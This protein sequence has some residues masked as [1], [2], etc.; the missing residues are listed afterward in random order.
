MADEQNQTTQEAQTAA[1]AP[2][3]GSSTAEQENPALSAAQPAE[4]TFTQSELDKIL[5]A[6][7]SKLEKRFSAEKEE[8]E[9][10]AAM[11]SEEKAAHERDKREKAL[12][13]REAELTRRE[14]S[15][16][17][18]ELLAK[19]NVPAVMAAAVDISDADGI[20][21]SAAS[22]AKDF[23]EAVSA[24]VARRLAGA[25]PKKGTPDTKDPFLDGLGL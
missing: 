15:A 17:A 6:E 23:R 25:P 14:R 13:D 12:A 8:A 18:R 24:E 16:L 11:T 7:R 21:S 9:R 2:T 3:E 1:P 20:E 19:E 10:T 4:K 22:V 5:S